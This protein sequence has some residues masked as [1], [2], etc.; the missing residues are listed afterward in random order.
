[1]LDNSNGITNETTIITNT[2][3]DNSIL[4]KLQIPCK[5]IIILLKN[6]I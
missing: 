5:D 2:K 4:K 6:K 3:K 1:M